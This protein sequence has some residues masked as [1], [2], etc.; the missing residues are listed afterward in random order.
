MAREEDAAHGMEAEE[1]TQAAEAR[2]MQK[3]TKKAKWRAQ[4]LEGEVEDSPRRKK[5]RV[6][7]TNVGTSA[8][9]TGEADEGVELPEA[10]CKWCVCY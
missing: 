6:S 3:A 1:V 4:E 8:A 7:P 5:A 9:P 10:P 2:V